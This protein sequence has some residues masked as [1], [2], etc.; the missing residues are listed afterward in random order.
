MAIRHHGL[1]LAHDSTRI[2]WGFVCCCSA[3]LPVGQRPATTCVRS[4][5]AL[6]NGISCVTARCRA[7]Y[8]V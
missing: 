8:P 1:Q 2:S 4:Y 7:P 5:S 3:H 6:Q